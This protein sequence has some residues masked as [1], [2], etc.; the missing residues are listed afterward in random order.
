MPLVPEA[1]LDARRREILAAAHR[2]LARDGFRDASMDRIAAEAGLSVGALYRYFD[3]KEA[4]IE[5]LAGA[6]RVEL[7]SVLKSLE[8]G[9]GVE[10]L[11]TLISRMVASLG[12]IGEAQ[13]VVRFD[14]RIWGEALGQPR[15]QRLA[16]NSL[17]S[18]LDPI[19]AYVRSEQEAGGM[20]AGQDPDMVARALVS[21]LTGLELQLAFDPS[22][23]HNAYAQVVRVLLA[24]LQP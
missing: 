21:L 4:L 1:Y 8:P 6:G 24:S 9:S 22:L 23:D 2:C 12:P 7:Q 14:V 17:R 20:R 5:A 3:G 10:G 11:A 15:L 13:D 19:A 16:A 18:L